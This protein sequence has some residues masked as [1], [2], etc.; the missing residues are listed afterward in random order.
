[1]NQEN[2]KALQTQLFSLGF[3][4]FES[5]LVKKICF[6]PKNFV[7]DYETSRGSD[8]LNFTLFLER[9]STQNVYELMYYDASILK[10]IQF[11]H[12]VINA[13]DTEALERK[14]GSI[15]WRNMEVLDADESPDLKLDEDWSNEILIE[16]V[17][18]D[19]F[20]LQEI[21]EGK[22]LAL[23]LKLKF[24]SGISF[25]EEIGNIKPLKNNHEISQRF[26]IYAKQSGITIDEAHR[27]L[28]NMSMEK[29][30]NQIK[31]IGVAGIPEKIK[32]KTNKSLRL[33]KPGSSA[34][35]LKEI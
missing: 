3:K 30:V 12:T 15:D 7:F 32:S 6:K 11:Q 1:M 33:K 29:L 20:K 19:L 28:Q 25:L 5:A 2:I 23:N 22:K 26:Y 13:V 24:W 16:S 35:F 14:M 18:D 8:K 17:I 9:D 10:E 31:K 27:F 4:S 21:E 34:G